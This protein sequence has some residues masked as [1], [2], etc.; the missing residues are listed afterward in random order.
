MRIPY[1][2]RVFLRD[3]PPATLWILGVIVVL[4]LV[5]VVLG[6]AA[7]EAGGW[8]VRLL[9][10]TPARLIEDGPQGVLTMTFVHAPDA[11]LQILLNGLVLFSLGRWIEKAVGTRRFLALFAVVAA[12]AGVAQTAWAFLAG[13]PSRTVMGSTG[14]VIGVLTAFALL[15]PD[16][17]LRF[18]MAAPIRAK[19]LVWLALGMDLVLLIGDVQV[20]VPAHLG[21]MIAAFLMIRRP[22]RPEWRRAFRA[23]LAKLRR[24]MT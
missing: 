18:W 13:D 21:G 1:R 11:V 5:L 7:P 2:W 23:R 14:A 22:W 19:N 17:M 10:L 6:L 4:Y 20:D 24:A 8:I 15:F 3:Q 9:A 12:G 16:A